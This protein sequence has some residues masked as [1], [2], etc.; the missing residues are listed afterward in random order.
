MPAWTGEKK[1]EHLF[2]HMEQKPRG[3]AVI[4]AGCCHHYHTSVHE[5]SQNIEAR[6]K[7][8]YQ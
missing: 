8:D 6:Q 4:R 2:A 3:F 5:N 1:I 7:R